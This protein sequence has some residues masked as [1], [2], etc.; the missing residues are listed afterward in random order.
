MCRSVCLYRKVLD[1]VK[2][3]TQ[4]SVYMY[5]LLHILIYSCSIAD[6]MALTVFTN[7]YH[8]QQPKC[9]LQ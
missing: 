2:H 8:L 6:D 7:L 1:D 9:M 4:L 5:T 3:D